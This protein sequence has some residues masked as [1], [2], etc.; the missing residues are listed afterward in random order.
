MQ[1]AV[2]RVLAG[3]QL[4]Y[5]RMDNQVNLYRKRITTDNPEGPYILQVLERNL[6][7]NRSLIFDA[8][9]ILEFQQEEP[10]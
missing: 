9:V 1:G 3:G 4:L 6:E 8:S 10:T 2:S 7:Q 5:G